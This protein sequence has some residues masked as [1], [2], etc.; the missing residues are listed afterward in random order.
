MPLSINEYTTLSTKGDQCVGGTIVTF[1]HSSK[2][3]YN[4]Q[5]VV[6]CYLKQE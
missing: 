2:Y 3:A 5:H 4:K 1:H 6:S